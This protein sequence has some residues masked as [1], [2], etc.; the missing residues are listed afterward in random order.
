[1]GFSES[2]KLGIKR[3]AHFQCSLCHALGVEI[4]HITPE[5]DGG[6]DT[7]DNAAPLCPTCHET[8]GANPDKRKFIREARDFWYEVCAK[9]YASDKDLLERIASDVKGGLSK[10]DL[11]DAITRVLGFREVRDR[12]L[13]EDP[14]APDPRSDIEI[15]EALEELF[16]KIWY[17]RHQM[18]LQLVKEG[19][20]Q[21]TPEILKVAKQ[22]ARRVEKKYGKKNLGPWDPFEWGMLNGKMSALRWVL[23][24][25]WDFLDT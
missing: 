12:A 8:W 18:M 5:A 3:R 21:I 6:P 1:M 4:H 11:E 13:T 14:E 2:L 9:R 25:E 10:Q 24:D 20:T 7:E 17:D 19:K 16:D 23:G 22:A 15:L